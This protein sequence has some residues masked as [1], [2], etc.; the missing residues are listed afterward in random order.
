M[1][2]PVQLKRRIAGAAGSPAATGFKE[3]EVALNFPGAAGTTGTPELWAFDG[4]GWRRVNP[5]LTVGVA[6]LP[7]G[8]PGAIA[9]IGAAW[10]A[11]TPKPTDPLVIA[12]FAGTAYVKTGPGGAD[13]DWTALGAS[14]GDP[15][16]HN[17]SAQAASADIGAAWTAAAPTKSAGV[18]FALWKG[19]IYVLTAPAAPGTAASWSKLT[20]IAA[21]LTYKGNVDLTAAYA[22]PN[23]VWNTGDFGTVQTTGVV[24]ASW[25]GLTAGDAVKAGDLIFFDGTNYHV[26]ANE[27]D[28]SAY[29]PLT[30]TTAAK[31]MTGAAVVTFDVPAGTG[32]VTRIDGGDAAK[33]KLDNFTIDCG[34]Y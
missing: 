1:A 14:G 24:G 12:T 11:L 29:L 6:A 8:T 32:L 27:T 16:V 7:G 34:T 23:P 17:L 2:I 31:K 20:D 9:G 28:L 26:V 4:T 5:T 30:G 33:S 22:A 10:T 19:A 25:P 15:V 21:P 13:G 3:G 18:N